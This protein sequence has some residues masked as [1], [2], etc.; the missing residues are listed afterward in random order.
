MA[1][2]YLTKR[3]QTWLQ[4]LYNPV[5]NDFEEAVDRA[6]MTLKVNTPDA[7]VSIYADRALMR[8]VLGN[9][10]SNAV[11]YGLPES[12]VLVDAERS[13][14]SLVISV[15]NEG[16]GIRR[17][18]LER[19]FERFTRLDNETTLSRKG[20]GLGLCIVKEI[21]EHHGGR[22]WAESET[23]LMGKVCLHNAA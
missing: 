11:K 20:T 6:S 17:E 19:V 7:P 9:L 18:D 5:V 1:N 15:F 8:A 22:V 12:E 4:T 21:V 10:I 14:E 2:C 23:R 13:G 16:E 3:N